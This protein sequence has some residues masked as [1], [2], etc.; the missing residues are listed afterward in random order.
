MGYAPNPCSPVD[1]LTGSSGYISRRTRMGISVTLALATSFLL[2][3]APDKPTVP[4][5]PTVSETSKSSAAQK[6]T[7]TPKI[8][9]ISIST[10]TKFSI[11][12]VKTDQG[13][14]IRLETPDVTIEADRLRVKVNDKTCFMRVIEFPGGYLEYPDG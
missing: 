1:L 13:P 14:K 2:G 8:P 11:Y 3:A 10:G 7:V 6:S 12:P 5:R 9:M 4:A